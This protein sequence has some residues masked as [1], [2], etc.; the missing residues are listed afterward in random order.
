[1]KPFKNLKFVAHSI[2]LSLFPIIS[3]YSHNI[4]QVPFNYTL[5]ALILSLVIAISLL[6]FLNIKIN[7]IEQTSIYVSLLLI[8]FYSYGRVH[9]FVYDI[10]SRMPEKYADLHFIAGMH[11]TN[12]F[13]HI[14]VL[15]WFVVLLFAVILR[16][17]KLHYL[18]GF[19]N[20]MNIFSIV[21]LLFSVVHIVNYHISYKEF[22]P[23]NSEIS[24]MSD[25]KFDANAPDIYYFILDGY[26]RFDVLYKYYNYD[27]STF[28]DYLRHKGFFIATNSYANY[29]WTFLSLSSSLN[30]KYLEDET[31]D[32]INSNDLGR[33]YEIIKDNRV[34]K[35]LK[36]KGYKYIH[37]KSSWIGASE[38]KLADYQIGY[39][40]MLFKNDFSRVLADTT[41][42][43]FFGI[44]SVDLARIHM[45]NF[46]ALESV[47][48]DPSPTI[49]FSHILLPHHPYVFDREGNIKNDLTLRGQDK[50]TQGKMGKMWS[51]K[52]AYLDQLIFVNKKITALVD[53]LLE[54]SLI[55]PIIIIQSDH[56]PQVQD[57]PRQE[58]VK[59]R[60]S[61]LNAIY[62]P[63]KPKFIFNESVT[64]VNTFRILFNNYFNSDLTILPNK[65]YYSEFQKPYQFTLVDPENN[66]PE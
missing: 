53:T 51:Q 28:L 36:A 35:F 46:K 45:E 38:N 19:R 65:S 42:L 39:K 50:H 59:C 1:M 8:L 64:P 29:S 7:D 37:L 58:Y 61:I 48:D 57:A 52:N 47:P 34:I 41:L 14:G 18:S 27:N 33:L 3:L 10:I 55:P 16:V 60:L 49:T 54:K 25:N 40:K 30:F 12:F 31:K 20:F 5:K 2:A 9:A 62:S 21:L 44:S 23:T 26:A 13:L 22:N 32:L 43:K 56:G 63:G 66:L 4:D 6:Y 11:E 24:V 17:R 15:S